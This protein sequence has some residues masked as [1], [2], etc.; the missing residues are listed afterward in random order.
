MKIS[1]RVLLIILLLLIFNSCTNERTESMDTLTIHYHRYDKQIDNWT[2]WSWLD[3]VTI[4]VQPAGKDTFGLIFKLDISKYPKM[5]NINF[6]PKYK[7]WEGKDSPERHWI[8]TTN[9][10]IWVLQGIG[11]IYFEKPDTSPFVRKSLLEGAKEITTILS[12]PVKKSELGELNPV[13]KFHDGGKVAAAY[14]TFKYENVDSS[15]V[16]KITTEKRVEIDQLPATL[17]LNG[18]RAG[19]L[20]IRGVLDSSEYLS[21]EPLGAFYTS[22]QTTFKVYAPGA[23]QVTLKLYDE[24]EGGDAA[25]HE[26]NK[27]ERGVWGVSVTGDLINKYYTYSVQGVDKS[28]NPNVEVIDPYARCTTAHNGRGIITNDK[29]PVADTPEFDFRDAVIYEMHV[30]DFTIAENSGVKHKGKYLGFA[31]PGTKLPNS[32]F[33]TGV[34]H[35]VELGVN[36]V[37]IMPIQDFEFNN[38]DYFW[39]YMTVNFN[40]PDSWFATKNDARQISEFKL[41][42]DRLHRKGIKVVMDVVYNHTAEGSP[43]VRYNF[44]GLAPNFYYRQHLDGSYWNGSGCGNELRSENPMVRRFIVES[45][46][47]WVKEYK[48]DGFRFD[49]M[50]LHDMDTMREIVQTLRKINPDIFLYGEPWAAGDTPIK[51]TVKGTQK[52][53]GFAVFNDNFRDALKGPWYNIDP[54]FLQSGINFTGVKKGIIGSITDFA[55]SPQEVINYVVCHDG[56]TLWDHLKATM[57]NDS[58]ITDEQFKAMDKLA[59]A[60]LFTSQGVPFIHGGQEFLRSKFGSHNSYNQ[61]DEI[62]KVRWEL[63]KTNHDIFRYYK[64]LIKLRKEHPMFRMTSREEIENN[65]IFLDAM[66]FSVPTNCIAYKLKRGNLGDVWKEILVL[67]NPNHKQTTFQIPHDEWQM[68][69]DEAQAGTE[70]FRT[71]K[72]KTVKIA[73]I[74]AMVLYK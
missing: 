64:G 49:L 73:P 74:S 38:S 51:P 62:N 66:G 50:G 9:N 32:D 28:F 25:K 53:E 23:T 4:E 19:D 72:T 56:R 35:L 29:T 69:V 31:E 55:D 18:Y 3:D 37:Q 39:G 20:L 17:S 27:G 46:K 67:I 12:N 7:N 47:Y 15:D 61:P 2:I 54:G 11:T 40:S 13:V 70:S 71:V 65:L 24:P 8:R 42:V 63:K 10:E 60:I 43:N 44:N 16:L 14:T 45:L 48:V 34:D 30:R 59:A 5:G 52:G 36:T 22:S 58:T 57:Q 21:D 68:V 1:S 6:L 26:L 33:S 41:L